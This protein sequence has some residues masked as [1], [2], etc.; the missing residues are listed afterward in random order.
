MTLIAIK[1]LIKNKN[2]SLYVKY[3]K[4]S[5]FKSMEK[6]WRLLSKTSDIHIYNTVSALETSFYL[7]V[8]HNLYKILV[9]GLKACNEGFP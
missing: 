5:D 2:C 3:C 6:A 4:A 8:V 9:L 1:V 7:S